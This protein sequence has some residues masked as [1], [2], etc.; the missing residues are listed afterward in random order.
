MYRFKAVV[1]AA[2]LLAPAAWGKQKKPTG[3]A[4]TIPAP[5]REVTRCN[6]WVDKGQGVKWLT[7]TKTYTEVS[8]TTKGGG[9]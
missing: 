1:L 7:C 6:G 8:M 3:K 2:I 5:P 4:S 9:V